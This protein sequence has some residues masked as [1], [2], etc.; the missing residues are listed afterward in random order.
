MTVKK[1]Y[2]SFEIIFVN[3]KAKTSFFLQNWERWRFVAKPI[4]RRWRFPNSDR[5]V[6][7]LRTTP[8][9]LPPTIFFCGHVRRVVDPPKNKK[10]PNKKKN[11]K[12]S[13]DCVSDNRKTH[14]SGY[15]LRHKSSRMVVS[16]VR[17]L[18]STSCVVHLFCP[19]LVAQDV[20]LGIIKKSPVLKSRCTLTTSQDKQQKWE[21]QN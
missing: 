17:V 18:D 1:T 14:A 12:I 19:G 16:S 5:K 2:F 21:R 10:T 3:E 8:P 7:P 13:S 4:G 9:L 11:W 6:S 15:A 20:R